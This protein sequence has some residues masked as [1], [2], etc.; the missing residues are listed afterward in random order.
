MVARKGLRRALAFAAF[1]LMPTYTYNYGAN[2]AIDF[3][4]LLIPDTGQAGQPF[5]FA[6][7]E[8]Q[9]FTTIETSVWQSSM[10]FSGQA[11]YSTLPSAPIP[12]RRIAANALDSLANNSARLAQVMQILDVKLSADK[13]AQELR[14]SAQALRTADD[15]RGAFAIAE[16][17]NN[18]F[19]FRDRYWKS[20][21]RQSGGGVAV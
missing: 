4:R 14:A 13:A 18:V 9:A 2:P 15:N 20:V 1:L 11:G 10:F 21:Q 17:V 16:Q 7:Q 6:D 12:W 5:I 8:I 3:P 19:S